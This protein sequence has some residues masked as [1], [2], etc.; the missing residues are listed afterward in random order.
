MTPEELREA[1]SKIREILRP[2][3]NRRLEA[4][5]KRIS[6]LRL[7]HPALEG[8]HAGERDS[9]AAQSS[10][11]GHAN[12]SSRSE[13]TFDPTPH[14]RGTVIQRSPT[15]DQDAKSR[16]V[17]VAGAVTY[18]R[19]DLEELVA[20]GKRVDLNVLGLLSFSPDVSAELVEQAIGNV[21]HRGVL[22]ASPEVETVL[23]R[24]GM[25]V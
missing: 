12:P 21:R 17:I 10:S 20:A 11:A 16:K 8:L 13:R 6:F 7:A 15:P 18:S 25:K 23:K 9:G 24:K 5:V 1:S 2:F 14:A 3:Q 4:G 22:S 19:G